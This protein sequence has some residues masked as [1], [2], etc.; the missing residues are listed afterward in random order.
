MHSETA[1]SLTDAVCLLSLLLKGLVAALQSWQ[2]SRVD[3][4]RANLRVLQL[5]MPALLSKGVWVVNALWVQHC[6]QVHIDQVVEVLRS[7][8]AVSTISAAAWKPGL[9]VPLPQHCPWHHRHGFHYVLS[10]QNA[11]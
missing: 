10:R 6:I 9:E 11:E 5:V 8:L 4:L 2:S 1:D 7:T 3:T